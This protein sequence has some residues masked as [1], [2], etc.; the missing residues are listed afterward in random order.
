[1]REL[2]ALDNGHLKLDFGGWHRPQKVRRF[3]V[4]DTPVLRVRV[5][6]NFIANVS[7]LAISFRLNHL[8]I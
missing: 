6:V 3:W 4:P 1:M 2:E 7:S 5:R 8:L